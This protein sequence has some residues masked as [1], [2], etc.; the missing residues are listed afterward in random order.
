ML[1]RA[2]ERRVSTEALLAFYFNLAS[3]SHSAS[4]TDWQIHT[5]DGLRTELWNEIARRVRQ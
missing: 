4:M 5:I 2:H 3:I 1:A